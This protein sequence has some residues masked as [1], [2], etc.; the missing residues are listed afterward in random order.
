MENENKLY[1]NLELKNPIYQ[2]VLDKFKNHTNLT[3][4]EMHVI[5][6]YVD[7]WISMRYKDN[8]K[9]FP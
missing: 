6:H 8:F 1:E 4:I 2:D 7:N 5:Y 9:D 3:N